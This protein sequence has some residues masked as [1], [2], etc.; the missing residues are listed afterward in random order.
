MATHSSTLVWKIPW[1]KE[2]GRLYCSWGR[3]ELDMTEQLHSLIY[4]PVYKIT[5]K[6][7]C[8]ADRT[9]LRDLW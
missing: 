4:T 3:K 2:P 5:N 1:M 6:K 8:I 9:L 7:L